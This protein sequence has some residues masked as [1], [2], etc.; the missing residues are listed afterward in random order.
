MLLGNQGTPQDA[1]ECHPRVW[2]RVV[3]ICG[4]LPCPSA[5]YLRR[6]KGPAVPKRDLQKMHRTSFYIFQSHEDARGPHVIK[7]SA[8]FA[9]VKQYHVAGN[10][11]V[12]SYLKIWNKDDGDFAPEMTFFRTLKIFRELGCI[13]NPF[14]RTKPANKTICY[15][16]GLEDEPESQ[17]R[18]VL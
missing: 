2:S 5:S 18:P 15:L 1:Q 10:T 6:R 11:V 7:F 12:N 17:A 16:N 9:V 14:G 3:Q 4:V 8:P 13:V